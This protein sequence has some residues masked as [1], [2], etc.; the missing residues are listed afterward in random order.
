MKKIF[1]TFF[2]KCS[3]ENKKIIEQF[4]EDILLNREFLDN[5]VYSKYDSEIPTALNKSNL[6]IRKFNDNNFKMKLSLNTKEIVFTTRSHFKEDHAFLTQISFLVEKNTYSITFNLYHTQYP[7]PK[8]QLRVSYTIK[9]NF[10]EL[11]NDY[12]TLDIESGI[13]SYIAPDVDMNYGCLYIFDNHEVIKFILD[14]YLEPQLF[15]D[16]IM[17]NYDMD[18][19]EDELLT[20]IYKN[21]NILKNSN[22]LVQKIKNN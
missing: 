14:N 7:Y 18:I 10:L 2:E 22:S 20:A 19:D 13:N 3:D 21:A 9:D 6:R 1:D 17:L 5:S 15:K 4:K 8:N 11:S 16:L 12:D